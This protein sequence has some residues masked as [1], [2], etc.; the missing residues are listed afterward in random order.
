MTTARA[1][2]TR[3]LP[4]ASME[5]VGASAP[6]TATVRASGTDATSLA[7]ATRGEVR[8]TA[9]DARSTAAPDRPSRAPG[10]IAFVLDN[11][12]HTVNPDGTGLSRL[13]PEGAFDQDPAW[14]PSH[15]R[16]AFG[17]G[18]NIQ[19][20][21]ADGSELTQLTSVGLDKA[22]TWS[23]DGTRIAFS[24]QGGSAVGI[25]VM[26]SDGT[27]QRLLVDVPGVASRLSWSPD[28]R[29]IAFS[30][31]SGPGIWV[32]APDGSGL[33]KIN[34]T[35]SSPSWGPHGRIAFFAES[36][37]YNGD[38]LVMNRNGD[39]ITSLSGG[40]SPQIDANPAWS[41]DGSKIAFVS[42]RDGDWAIFTMSAHGTDVTRVTQGDTPAW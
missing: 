17:R 5:T 1:D 28:G 26:N 31:Y 36:S 8:A 33:R 29:Q 18:A 13:A 7:D 40:S 41:A 34:E 20:M 3:T 35:G 32:V 10:R 27:G 14:S 38:I 15:D 19:V 21:K 4:P 11:A 24:R 25:W 9:P 16:I 42:Y 23:P 30:A 12:I 6:T 2:V 37:P 39:G 22:P